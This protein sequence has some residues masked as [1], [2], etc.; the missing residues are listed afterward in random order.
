MNA[1][2]SAFAVAAKSALVGTQLQP[3]AATTGVEPVDALIAPATGDASERALLRAAGVLGFAR[4]TARR[5]PVFAEAPVPAA[6]ELVARAGPL[7]GID[8]RAILD[9]RNDVLL[10]EWLALARRFERRVPEELLPALFSFAGSKTALHDALRATAGERGRWL[11]AKRPAWTW[12]RDPVDPRAT[13]AHGTRPERAAALRLLRE[14]EPDAARDL[15]AATFAKDAASDRAALLGVLAYGLGPA[16]LAFVDACARDKSVE[17]RAVAL[18]LAYALGSGPAVDRAAELAKPLLRVERAFLKR[19][20]VVRLPEAF[21]PEM[22]AAG[23]VEKPAREGVGERTWWFEQILART[24]L[25]HWRVTFGVDTRGLFGFEPPDE[26]AESIAR[27]WSGAVARY[28]DAAAA[29]DLLV[30]A[31]ENPVFSGAALEAGVGLVRPDVR[32]REVGA[33]LAAG[34]PRAS[35]FLAAVPPPWSVAFSLRAVAYLRTL[36]VMS[37][38]ENDPAWPYGVA[39][40]FESVAERLDPETPGTA[41]DWPD[42]FPWPQQ[43]TA[44]ERFVAAFAFRHDAFDHLKA[45]T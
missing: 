4:R 14:R 23:L 5:A 41:N 16:D 7:A 12:L 37:T 26:F 29:T 21:T 8:L 28:R 44:V 27:G 13:F 20:L 34:A 32:E 2:R 22:A 36:A 24:P 9:A 19:K 39:R 42:T 11:A 25:A 17:V 1:S 18:E 33:M 10:A 15:L 6:D 3:F 30:L 45:G 31:R 40:L 35:E 38:R 43:R